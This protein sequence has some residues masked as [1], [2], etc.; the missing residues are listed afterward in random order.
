[1]TLE[2]VPIKEHSER[3]AKVCHQTHTRSL[4]TQLKHLLR[5]LPYPSTLKDF[6]AFGPSIDENGLLRFGI[7][8]SYLHL[9][10]NIIQ[11]PFK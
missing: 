5:L 11:I 8:S 7:G 3:Q 4:T 10:V 2:K 6:G 9:W 1:M